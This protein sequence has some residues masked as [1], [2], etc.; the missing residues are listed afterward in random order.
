MF[1]TEPPALLAVSVF[2]VVE[3]GG[4]EFALEANVTTVGA[5]TGTTDT[6]LDAGAVLITGLLWM[7]TRSGPTPI[8]T[9][10]KH[11]GLPA[12]AESK[13]TLSGSGPKIGV[14]ATSTWTRSMPEESTLRVMSW[15]ESGV[16]PIDP[17]SATYD[18]S[19]NV[20]SNE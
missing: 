8:E 14:V 2:F 18:A 11:T 6:A 10:V 5:V 15:N 17:R 12:R 4:T 16:F 19:G 13:L 20:N 7:D 1:T 9:T 3:I